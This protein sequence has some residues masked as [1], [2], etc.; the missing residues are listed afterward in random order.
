MVTASLNRAP[1]TPVRLARSLPARSTRW[2]LAHLCGVA[3]SAVW[4]AGSCRSTDVH[5]KYIVHHNATAVTC[6]EAPVLSRSAGAVNAAAT[7]RAAAAHRPL[8]G[9]PRPSCS[10]RG[11]IIATA[12]AT[13]VAA[14]AA[15]D[16]DALIHNDGEDGVGAAGELVHGGAGGRARHAALLQQAHQVGRAA[17]QLLACACRSKDVIPARQATAHHRTGHTK[18][19]TCCKRHHGRLRARRQ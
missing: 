7:R 10:R 15:A 3:S 17:R 12:A 13:A 18:H 6:T 9:R 19:C 5:S 8:M 11:G 2:N 14:A 4:P 1:T 16:A